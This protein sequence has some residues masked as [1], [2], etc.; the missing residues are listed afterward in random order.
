MPP[1]KHGF[2]VQ[3]LAADNEQKRLEVSS[4]PINA[5]FKKKCANSCFAENKLIGMIKQ[6]QKSY[7]SQAVKEVTSSFC[8]PIICV[9]F[10][11][12]S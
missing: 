11:E 3:R 5:E 8:Y 2:G 1:L 10:S 12:K 6:W 4:V 9:C 7:F